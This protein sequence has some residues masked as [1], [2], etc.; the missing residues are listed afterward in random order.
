MKKVLS[1]FLVFVLVFTL[2]VSAL[3][4]EPEGTWTSVWSTSMVKSTVGDV[5]A[6]G[7]GSLVGSLIS[8]R[9]NTMR[10]AITPQGSGDKLRLVLANDFGTSPLKIESITVGMT[11]SSN[12]RYVK[13]GTIR[14]VTYGGK[15]AFS[16]PAGERLT[17]DPVD[18][19]PAAGVPLTVNIYYGD[20]EPNTMG[21]YGGDAYT[22]IMGDDYT[23]STGFGRFLEGEALYS[24]DST[25]TGHYDLIP[26]LCEVDTFGTQTDGCIVVFGDST[27]TNEVSNLFAAGLR[28][29]GV[30]NLSVTQAA[31]KGNRLVYD[32]AG[33]QGN[34]LGVSGLSRF[35][36]DV[37]K[38]ANVKAVIV[39]LGV[40]DVVHPNIPGMNAPAATAEELGAGYETLAEMARSA[41]VEICICA[42]TPWQGYTRD[43][44]VE[45]S[46]EIDALRVE[47][48]EWLYSSL[49]ACSRVFPDILADGTALKPEYTTDGAHLT[50]TG[51]TKLAEAFLY[52]YESVVSPKSHDEDLSYD[53][54]SG[55]LVWT[56]DTGRAVIYARGDV[57][58]S[59]KADLADVSSLFRWWTGNLELTEL[60]LQLGDVNADGITD[61]TDAAALYQL[62]E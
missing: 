2:S 24:D 39:K 62:T 23:Y 48:N 17:T 10:V 7:K 37:L 20:T 6:Q 31:I 27:V 1:L 12:T 21:L 25:A 13:S 19:A 5:V 14:T 55:N 49:P 8:M 43:G 46:E 3:A 41:G 58:R 35:E 16:I 54:V 30:T 45:W 57:D 11:D 34:L 53:T 32:G 40:N 38:Q 50:A 36:N 56:G 61:L 4:E 60:S 22:H 42:R 47:L 44:S 51:Q 28:S 29:S 33:S 9:G 15:E 59:G 52:W 18:Y 26:T